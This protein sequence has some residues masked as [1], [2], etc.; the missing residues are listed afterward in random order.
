MQRVSKQEEKERE[1][2]VEKERGANVEENVE[3]K[4]DQKDTRNM[5][6]K[7]EEGEKISKIKSKTGP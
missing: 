5:G 3:E 6:T 4:E 7:N 2:K 1:A